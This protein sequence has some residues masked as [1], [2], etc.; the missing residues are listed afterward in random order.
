MPCWEGITNLD[1]YNS[2]L[3]A[4]NSVQK[5]NNI[6]RESVAFLFPFHFKCKCIVKVNLMKFVALVLSVLLSSVCCAQSGYEIFLM[7][8]DFSGKQIE[9]SNPTNITNHPGYDNQPFFSY[10]QPLVYY[11]SMS[12]SGQTDIRVYNYQTNETSDFTVT[13]ESEFSPTVTPDHQFV[14]CISQ[15]LARDQNLVK[16]P[17]KGGDPVM[18]INSMKVGYHC[19]I[20]SERV[21]LFILDDTLN[22]SLHYY[23]LES[24]SDKLFSNKPG[25]CISKI[26]GEDA[27]AFMDKSNPNEFVI[28]RFDL[29]TSTISTVCSA[30]NKHEDFIWTKNGLMMMSDGTSLFSFDPTTNDGWKRIT[31]T[32]PDNKI[33]GITRIALNPNNSK[34]AVVV[35]E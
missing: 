29:K 34:I 18:L 19:W 33:K 2:N 23:N 28:N 6:I 5:S 4:T 10:D 9:L 3:I 26:P 35:N 12:D 11:T 21:I 15:T 1:K 22:N 27:V 31:V 14:S 17:I 7:D 24:K 13:A 8:I 25:R 20:D 32:D 30:L 16:F